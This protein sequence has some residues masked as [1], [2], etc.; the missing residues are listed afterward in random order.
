MATAFYRGEGGTIWEM[1]LPLPEVM[2]EKVVK[3]YL[4]RVNEDGSPY[5]EPVEQEAPSLTRAS[6]KAEWVGWAVR[7]GMDPDDAEAMTK[8]D[9]IEL[10]GRMTA[11]EEG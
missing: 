9:L 5:E 7:N 8:N 6:S 10:H 1:S 11:D 2:Q 3:G 4:R